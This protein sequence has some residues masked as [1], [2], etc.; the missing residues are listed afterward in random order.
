[1]IGNWREDAYGKDL[2]QSRVAVPQV[3]APTWD[4]TFRAGFRAPDR[5]SLV[6]KSLT[7]LEVCQTALSPVSFE[8]QAAPL[9]LSTNIIAARPPADTIEACAI[10]S[11][12]LS[13]R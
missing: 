6:Q 9:S 10:A 7:P 12:D 11:D 1:M 13:V 5:D 2:A 3:F 8:T 4:T